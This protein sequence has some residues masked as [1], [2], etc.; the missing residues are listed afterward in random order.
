MTR[1]EKID[2]LTQKIINYHN[3]RETKSYR[4]LAE[5]IVDLLSKQPTDD[6]PVG[7]VCEFDGANGICIG[8]FSHY[9][10]EGPQFVFRK[11][12][13]GMLDCG[14]GGFFLR[15]LGIW[16]IPEKHGGAP[17]WAIARAY[18][19]TWNIWCRHEADVNLFINKGYTI[20][21]RPEE[22]K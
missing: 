5:D 6:I 11:D 16:D 18:N 19:G 2:L 22:Q 3:K 10:D 1:E 7:A 4:Y 8:Y 14:T 17:S 20:E 15:E 12:E 13:I 9:D 21:R